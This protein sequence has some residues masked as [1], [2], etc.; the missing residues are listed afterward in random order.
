MNTPKTST[1]TFAN[2]LR[3]VS[4]V[5]ALSFVGCG[6]V[7]STKYEIGSNHDDLGYSIWIMSDQSSQQAFYEKIKEISSTC[8][9]ATGPFLPHVTLMGHV[10]GSEA[11]VLDKTRSMAERVA[12]FRMHLLGFGITDEHFKQLFIEIERDGNMTMARVL[13]EKTFGKIEPGE[14]M[15][16]L[17]LAYGN[18]ERDTKTRIIIA[19]KGLLDSKFDAKVLAVVRTPDE[20]KDWKMIGRFSLAKRQTGQGH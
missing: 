18:I 6:G 14:Y 9:G 3:T 20:L 1:A 8:R 10:Q 5:I 16:H 4:A 7:N 2:A 13:A 19:A 15:P 12:P 11:E 17:S